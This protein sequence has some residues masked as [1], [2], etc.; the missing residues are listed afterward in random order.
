MTRGRLGARHVAISFVA[1]SLLLIAT[2]P[3]WPLSVALAGVGAWVGCISAVLWGATFWSKARVKIGGLR[4]RYRVVRRNAGTAALIGFSLLLVQ[5]VSQSL[6]TPS[7][8]TAASAKDSATVDPEQAVVRCFCATLSAERKSEA[9]D[10]SGVPTLAWPDYDG[11]LACVKRLSGAGEE[12]AKR[13]WL[14]QRWKALKGN[15]GRAICQSAGMPVYNGEPPPV[16]PE[17]M[18]AAR[19]EFCRALTDPSADALPDYDPGRPEVS[20]NAISDWAKRDEAARDARFA[21]RFHISYEEADA[22]LNR[23]AAEHALA[24]PPFLCPGEQAPPTTAELNAPPTKVEIANAR[25]AFCQADREHPEKLIGVLAG[26]ALEIYEASTTTR[27]ER[28][29]TP[30]VMGKAEDEL[31]K[32]GLRRGELLHGRQL[33]QE[34]CN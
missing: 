3:R 33:T 12:R 20:R 27:V 29:R 28:Y 1:I 10:N 16:G 15:D 8:L 18:R 9:H 6:T 23:A 30:M 31:L 34:F 11:V 24:N 17:I 7:A 14:D 5:V 25:A 32:K 26:R 19:Q 13:A 2:S 4:L 21:A 22:A